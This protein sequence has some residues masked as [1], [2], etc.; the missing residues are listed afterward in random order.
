V[1]TSFRFTG[2]AAGGDHTCGVTTDAEIVC[3]GGGQVADVMTGVDGQAPGTLRL[4]SAPG[5]SRHFARVTAGVA[6]ACATTT[7]GMIW[8][9][10]DDRQR[11]LGAARA[12]GDAVQ[13]VLPGR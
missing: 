10:G 13:V 1:A 4:A 9:W 8:C 11:Q 12:E 7:A 5:A 3:W 2:I 6:H